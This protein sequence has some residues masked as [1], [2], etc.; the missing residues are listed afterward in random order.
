MISSGLGEFTVSVIESGKY[1]INVYDAKGLLVKAMTKDCSANENVYVGVDS[2]SGIY[3][4]RVAKD[5]MVM[6]R[7][8]VVKK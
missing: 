1:A 8:K 3:F 4:V 5:G 7:E 2:P 6:K